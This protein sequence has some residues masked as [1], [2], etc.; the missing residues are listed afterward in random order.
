MFRI[1]EAREQCGLTQAALAEQ[2]GIN[3]VTL[4]GYET[5]KHDP[6]SDTLVKIAQ[7]CNVT[8]DFLLDR[9]PPKQNVLSKIL[10]DRRRSLGMSI[11]QLVEA[12]GIPKG[13]VTKVLTG[14]SQN[15][16]LETVKA[17]AYAMGLTL[18]DLT[19][20]D[21]SKT[22]NLT[23]SALKLAARYDALNLLGKSLVEAAVSFA[24]KNF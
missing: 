6:K 24:E 8:V 16:S 23:N 15:P 14:V 2:L 9:T 22:V 5:G 21:P 7:I 17:I 11:D 20:P 19:E 4:S 13:T 1:R 3:G 10:S 12:S 18:D